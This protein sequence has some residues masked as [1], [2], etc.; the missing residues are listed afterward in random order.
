MEFYR[1]VDDVV[2][3]KI[4]G[5]VK[6]ERNATS[7]VLHL[8]RE[9]D[10]R[11]LHSKLQYKSLHDFAVK[12][13][14]Y[15]DDQAWRRISAMHLQKELPQIESK[16]NDGTLSLSTLS[17][18]KK[19]FA[20]E[21]RGIDQAPRVRTSEEKLEVLAKLENVSR[22]EAEKI[23]VN[24]TGISAKPVES[25]R[26]IGDGHTQ[27]KTVFSNDTIEVIGRLKGLLAHSHPGLSTS[28][29]IEL[30][31]MQLLERVYPSVRAARSAERKTKQVSHKTTQSGNAV[32]SK[33]TAPAQKHRVV[34]RYIPADVRH[35][36]WLRD[37]GKCTSCGS[38]YAVQLEHMIPFAK[39]GEAT[40]DNTKLLCRSC[41]QRSAIEQFG[42]QKMRRFIRERSVL[43]LTR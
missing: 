17:L 40:V 23:L 4:E 26:V 35:H 36:V 2:I 18:A 22:R 37:G 20:Q 27:L 32:L 33:K 38:Q 19:I 9:V 41:N 28:A 39:G 7:V 24:E 42:L 34:N 15:S 31:L 3:T 16:I 1:L 14:K 6:E 10:R 21:A 12:R 43:Y 30:S 25:L 5:A 29:L 8:L 13:L 11:R